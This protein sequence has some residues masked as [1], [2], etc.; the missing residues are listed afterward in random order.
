MRTLYRP[1]IWL[2]PN[3]PLALLPLGELESLALPGRELQAG[4]HPGLIA[5]RLAAR[6]T[7]PMLAE[8]GRYV[9]S[10]G[11]ADWWI[12]RGGSSTRQAPA[13]TPAQELAHAREH[14]FLPRRYRDPF[15]RED[16]DTESLVDLRRPRPARVETRDALGNM[17]RNAVKRL[18]RAAAAAVT[19]PN[20]NRREVAFDA[21]GMV[22]GTAVMGKARAR[23]SGDSSPASMPIWTKP[24]SRASRRSARRSACDPAARHARGWFTTCSPTSAPRTSADPQPAVVY[25]SR[26]RRTTPTRRRGSRPR[27]STPSP[28]PTAS[29]ARS[30]RR[31]RPSPDRSSAGGAGR[32]DS[33]LGGHR[34]DGLQQQ[35]Q[36]GPAVRAVLQRHPSLRVRRARRR[37]PDPVLRPV[38][39]VVATLHPNHTWEKVV[40]DPWQ[41]ETWDVNDTVLIADP[42]TDPDVGD[43]FGRL[44]TPTYLPTWHAA[45]TAARWDRR[46]RLPPKTAVHAD[47]P[48][49]AHLDSLGRT[50]L[51]IAH[52]RIER[53]DGSIRRRRVLSRRG[54]SSTSKATSAR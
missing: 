36:A 17:R 29:A 12:P 43:F 33:A 19:D 49:V 27:S 21:L 53:D 31:S 54:S 25:P 45:A 39:R 5:R 20:G 11:D 34:L 26:A 22:A 14:F 41:Q 50:F 2:L 6:V 13:T 4:V 30:R 15:H 28:T 8:R 44:P 32:S 7:D 24:R 47:T 42:K 10:E 48:A 35:G 37:Q 46:N 3:D 16:F 9:H 38:G 51:T 40:F 1:T 52:N 18:P 23:P